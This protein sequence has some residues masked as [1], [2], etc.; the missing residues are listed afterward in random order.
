MDSVGL[1]QPRLPKNCSSL[2]SKCHGMS[3]TAF[4][5]PA[6]EGLLPA[7]LCELCES[8]GT[9]WAPTASWL[10]LPAPQG[11]L[12][13]G[14]GGSCSSKH[15]PPDCRLCWEASSFS[16]RWGWSRPCAAP[17]A[18]SGFVEL[19]AAFWHCQFD[20]IWIPAPS[21]CPQLGWLGFHGIPELC[22]PGSASW[23]RTGSHPTPSALPQ[24][25]QQAR[26]WDR[27]DAWSPTPSLIP[28]LFR[29][30]HVIPFQGPGTEVVSPGRAV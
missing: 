8:L 28:Q 9:C 15:F 7:E 2:C 18:C 1:G 17:S 23:H 6:A 11:E 14:R 26:L 13:T 29:V 12:Q 20:C 10:L 24:L 22:S 4:P 5:A 30:F 27:M 21:L 25:L 19:L 16:P 3:A